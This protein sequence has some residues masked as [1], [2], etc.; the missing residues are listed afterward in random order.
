MDAACSVQMLRMPAEF[1][2]C[3]VYET[4]MQREGEQT[5]TTKLSESWV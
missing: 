1:C 2:Q 5:I 3:D 4:D